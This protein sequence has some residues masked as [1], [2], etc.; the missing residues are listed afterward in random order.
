V[1]EEEIQHSFIEW[2]KG[3]RGYKEE[4]T[5][6]NGGAGPLVDSAG[7]IG[8]IP[9]LIEFKVSVTES[10]ITYESNR[11]SSI[12]RKIRNS[13]ER[14][15]QS[16]LIRRW[17]RKTLPLVWIIAEQITSGGEYA[18]QRLLEGR[19]SEW[20]FIY[21]VGIWDGKSYIDLLSG[22]KI[23]PF[24]KSLANLNL[25]PMPS[26]P[27][28]RNPPRGMSEQRETARQR[29]VQRLF[30][31]A[32]EKVQQTSLT[33]QCNRDNIML[34]ASS[35]NVGAIWPIDSS[36]QNGLCIA[37]QVERLRDCFNVVINAASLPGVPAS[38]RGFLG[39]RRFLRSRDEIKE[40]FE[41]VT[42][43]QL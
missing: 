2:L 21:Q 31:F 42:G 32:M 37:A 20:C 1:I 16:H 27:V 41:M 17:N 13:I 24:L 15:H 8:S 11:V 9:H 19:S 30:D 23:A 34:K 38:K 26:V 33:M 7:L 3:R 10:G 36:E 29:G 6:P 4:F 18:L 14:L 43:K 40:F 28:F 5:D 35:T 25:P 39:P 22:P 12:E